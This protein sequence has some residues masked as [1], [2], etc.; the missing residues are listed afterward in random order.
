[1]CVHMLA[2]ACGGQVSKSPG[3]GVTDGCCNQT[4]AA[5][6]GCWEPNSGLLEEQDMLLTVEPSL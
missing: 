2:G 3:A 1:M 5:Q 6:S 4:G